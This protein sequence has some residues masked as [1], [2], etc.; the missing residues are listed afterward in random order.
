M[1]KK[2]LAGFGGL[3]VI[4]S[5]T[6]FTTATDT[7]VPA[8]ALDQATIIRST[9]T[10]WFDGNGTP[11]VIPDG[12]IQ[13]VATNNGRGNVNVRAFGTLPAGAALPATAMHFDNANTG[14]NC[15]FGGTIRFSGVTTPSGQFSFRCKA[16]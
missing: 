6:A 5:V 8:N 12:N 3:A 13:I 16:P 2:F 15:G 14:F 4:A 10:I 7:P 1:Y 11:T 9:G